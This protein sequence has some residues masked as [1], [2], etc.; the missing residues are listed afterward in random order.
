ML[1]LMHFH[2]QMAR[3]GGIDLMTTASFVL[4]TDPLTG[5]HDTVS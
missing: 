3:G 2:K 5:H 4:E 1:S